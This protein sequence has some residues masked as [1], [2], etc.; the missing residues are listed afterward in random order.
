M[1]SRNKWFVSGNV[2]EIKTLKNGETVIQMRGKI[3]RKDVF[4]YT[5]KLNCKLDKELSSNV[6]SILKRYKNAITVSGNLK[7]GRRCYLMVERL[8]F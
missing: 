8:S 2:T 6:V 5:T 4:S 1:V 3:Y 7:F